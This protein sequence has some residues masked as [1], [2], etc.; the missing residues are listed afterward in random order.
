M[1][2]KILIIDNEF[3]EITAL[4]IILDKLINENNIIVTDNNEDLYSILEENRIGI[5]FIGLHPPNYTGLQHLPLI[6]K[7]SNFLP[8]IIVY[9]REVHQSI[10][11]KALSMGAN[12]YFFFKQ[13]EQEIINRIKIQIKARSNNIKADI[14]YKKL[15]DH[16]SDIFAFLD[17]NF[18]IRYLNKEAERITGIPNRVARGKN[19]Y[20]LFP[21]IKGTDLENKL[22]NALDNRMPQTLLTPFGKKNKQINYEIN[23]YP[24]SDGIS[25]FVRDISY[26]KSTE[27]I[28]NIKDDQL[29]ESEQDDVYWYWNM[30]TGE[31]NLNQSW[32]KMLGYE[33]SSHKYDFSWWINNIH[34]EDAPRFMEAIRDYVKGY[35]D[36]YEL[37]YRIKTSDNSWRWMWLR[38]KCTQWDKKGNPVSMTGI[39]TDIT[40]QKNLKHS[41]RISEERFLF[42]LKD[43]PIMV[44]N[45]DKE[46]RY[47]WGHNLSLGF[48]LK[49]I[50]GKTD[51]DILPPEEANLLTEIKSKVLNTGVGSQRVVKLTYNGQS[52]Y[53][54][55]TVEPLYDSSGIVSGITSIAVEITER[56]KAEENLRRTNEKLNAIINGSLQGIITISPNG[57]IISWN[58]AAEEIFGW[59]EKEI[60]G[61][62]NPIIP[63]D[64]MDFFRSIRQRSMQG[65]TFTGVE[66]TAQN[67]D[68]AP[69]EISISNSLLRDNTGKVIGLIN[70]IQDISKRKKAEEIVKKFEEIVKHMHIGLHVYYLE[71]IDDELSLQ[72]VIT[73]DAGLII[74]GENLFDQKDKNI[75]QCFPNLCEKGIPRAFAQV[76][77]D[78]KPVQLEVELKD[79][80][81]GPLFLNFKAFP[82]P[83][84]HVG[85]LFEDITQHKILQEELLKASKLESVGLLAGGIA[86][87]FNNILTVILG[88]IS[89]CKNFIKN[90][91]QV[92]KKLTETVKAIGQAKELTYQLQ[93]FSKGGAP[94]K[95]TSSIADLI[96]EVSRFS[97]SGSNVHCIYFFPED[98]YL[99]DIDE[100]QI[101]QVINNLI[102]NA[103]HAMPEGGTIKITANN[104]TDRNVIDEKQLRDDMEYIQLAITDQGFGIKKEYIQKIFDPYFSTKQEGSGLGLAITYSVIKKHGGYITVESEEGVGTTFYLYLPASK[105]TE[106]K[107]E[108][109]TI[110]MVKGNGR[111]LIMDDEKPIRDIAE[112]MLTLLGYETD[113][114]QDGH[115]AINKYLNAKEK[116]TPFDVIIMDLTIP[117]GMGGE[118]TIKELLDVDP[119]VRA[120]V[121]SG[122]SSDPILA[123][124]KQYGFKGIVA[125]PYLMEELC[126]AL[127]AVINE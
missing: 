18:K 102:I 110:D 3:S 119:Q 11:E 79:L 108:E 37:E 28:Y 56:K 78:G 25:I 36:Q 64:K 55:F 24:E 107:K 41:M 34:P 40:E 93:T 112:E 23:V 20:A 26:L 127:D 8:Q 45:Q 7:I 105:V 5:I 124:Y 10:L 16:M 114:A 39:H 92:L 38:G 65:E 122:Y 54:H 19:I 57:K 104:V 59:R 83:N 22:V 121:S 88:N 43:S 14:K 68:G 82:L 69:V 72:L 94:V 74:L 73:N 80:Q 106:I 111:V 4:K 99:V 46:L 1:D 115:Q 35:K 50:L 123:N 126:S 44:F 62:M 33:S 86:H 87:D 113:C 71:E 15:A 21:E 29:Q 109:K 48:S 96:Q 17:N 75:Q 70:F 32:K 49:I 30:K 47:F 100:S 42:A 9:S 51:I 12:D 81:H 67:K 116:G 6:R 103:V 120:I 118:K 76:I 90:E 63:R 60:I 97:L 2:M 52:Y 77:R 61:K 84:N 101:S 58:K 27:E 31:L 98:L 89:L 66:L 13:N 95:K 53:Y 91:E 125:K 85:V 117:G